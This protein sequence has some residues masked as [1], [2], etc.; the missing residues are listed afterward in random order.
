M[1]LNATVGASI[2]AS[3]GGTTPT[4]DLGGASGASVRAAITASV[5][6]S[7][8]TGAGQGDLMFADRR[9][10]TD[11][12]TENLDLNGVLNDAFGNQIDALRVKAVVIKAADANTTDLTFGGGANAWATLFGAT[13]AV[14]VRPGAT[15]SAFAGSADAVAWTVTAGTGDNIQVVNAAGADADYDIVIIAASA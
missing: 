12:A 13:A 11:G 6:L 5:S 7:N 9:T 10:V 8:G 14:T 4:S 2:S 15:V 1:S 3:Q